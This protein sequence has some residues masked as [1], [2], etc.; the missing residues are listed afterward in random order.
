LIRQLEASRTL[1]IF[2]TKSFLENEWRTLQIKTSHQLF[3]KMKDKTLIAILGDDIQPNELDSELGQILRKNTCI[4]R[5]HTLFWNLLMSSL[6]L[7]QSPCGSD[8]SQIYSDMY[9]S[10]VP[11][12]IV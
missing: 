12:A 3:A 5:N 4:Q 7:R 2:L 9:G 8:S 11:S 10:I 1:I 6:P